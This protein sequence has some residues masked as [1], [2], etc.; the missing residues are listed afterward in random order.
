VRDS[1]VHDDRLA[2]SLAITLRGARTLS[3]QPRGEDG[4]EVTMA[5]DAAGLAL[6]M[7]MLR[8]GA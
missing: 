5:L 4:Y 8:A 7:R 2:A 1:V 3:I 6:V